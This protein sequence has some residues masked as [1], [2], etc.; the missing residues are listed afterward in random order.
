MTLGQDDSTLK[1][2]S[3]ICWNFDDL[4]AKIPEL[5]D[6]DIRNVRVKKISS[7]L[8]DSIIALGK[9][10]R[11][12]IKVK[13]SSRTHL[14]YLKKNELEGIEPEILA[15]ALQVVVES[16]IDTIK[17]HKPSYQKLLQISS[18]RD[19]LASKVTE[20]ENRLKTD[21]LSFEDKLQEKNETIENLQKKVKEVQKSHQEIERELE[22]SKIQNIRTSQHLT[23]LQ[24][25]PTQ[26]SRNLLS[27]NSLKVLNHQPSIALQQPDGSSSIGVLPIQEFNHM[28][29]V[30]SE[31][32]VSKSAQFSKNQELSQ[33]KMQS[34][35]KD[36]LLN[37]S[38]PCL[39]EMK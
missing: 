6:R 5:K 29:K 3:S 33:L 7:K 36:Q 13:E 8:A 2:D 35:K 34:L 32:K 25:Q 4:E 19:V 11:A 28:K 21:P 38:R 39:T 1:I 31:D 17:A 30:L 9:A 16:L 23:L 15:D 24:E 26:Q 22:E 14:L 20:L 27:Q 10:V 12:E 18:E 37:K